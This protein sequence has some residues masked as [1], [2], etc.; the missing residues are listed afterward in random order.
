MSNKINAVL[1][2]DRRRKAQI[3]RILDTAMKIVTGEGGEALTM[4]NLANQL[5]Y[6]AG[7][8]Y[9]YYASKDQIIAELQI[10]CIK[11]FDTLF[12]N[13]KA[14]V[15]EFFDKEELKAILLIIVVGKIFKHYAFEEPVKFSFLTNLMVEPKVLVNDVDASKVSTEF[16]NLFIKISMLFFEASSKKLI[17]E[18][19]PAEKALVYL[20]SLQGVLQLKKLVRVDN[21]LFDMENLIKNLMTTLLLGWGI[22]QENLNKLE[23]N[24]SKIKI[25]E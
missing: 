24:L 4:Q 16:K 5:D 21:S 18:G 8:L 15:E 14:K 10:R 25:I 20:S 12:D 22:S 17:S 11:E 23:S 6:T 2:K 1:P 9:R 19:N 3:E 13:A 7:A